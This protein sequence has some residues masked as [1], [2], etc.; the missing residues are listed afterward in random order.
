MQHAHV[1]ACDGNVQDQYEPGA[2]TYVRDGFIHAALVG[3]Q[4]V[5]DDEASTSGVS[6]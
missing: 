2:G 3:T 1:R 5:V 4:Q 6:L